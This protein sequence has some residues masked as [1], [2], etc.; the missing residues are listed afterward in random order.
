M[1]VGDLLIAKQIRT[2][3]F[4]FAFRRRTIQISEGY[5]ALMVALSCQ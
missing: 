4:V 3:C 2:N 1:E 5:L